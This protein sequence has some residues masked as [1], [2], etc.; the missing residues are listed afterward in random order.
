M[1]E[2]KNFIDDLGITAFEANIKLAGLAIISDSG[3]LIHQTDNW[4]LRNQTG[5][6]INVING[7]KTF[8]ISGGKF[9]VIETNSDGIIASSDS[10]MGFIIFALFQGGVLLSYAMPNADPSL[11][12]TFLKN[13]A[14]RLNG[15]I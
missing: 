11:A 6:I 9:S 8:D 5:T 10:G 14:M 12:L 4:N 13:N 1:V 7:E 2:I 15:Q 3:D